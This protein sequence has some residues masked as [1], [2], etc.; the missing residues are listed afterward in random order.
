MVQT[1]MFLSGNSDQDS[2]I[3]TVD[4]GFKMLADALDYPKTKMDKVDA[5]ELQKLMSGLKKD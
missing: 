1:E 3:E 5:D 4:D 2:A